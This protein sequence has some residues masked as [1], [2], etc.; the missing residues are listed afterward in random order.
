MGLDLP[1]IQLEVNRRAAL[2]G[3]PA[4]L[5]PTYGRT[6]DGA[7]PHLEVNE[8]GYHYVVVERGV[9]LERMTTRDLDELLYA[10][11]QSV[12]FSLACQFE[13]RHRIEGEDCRRQMF[14][15]QEELL[16][17]LDPW[18]ARRRWQEHQD[19]LKRHPFSI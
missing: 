6:E 17:K 2:I 11:F 10:V 7:R 1:R 16:Q 9:E 12:T 19:I 15:C 13:V 8:A 5:L 4:A 18:W 14:R 3:A